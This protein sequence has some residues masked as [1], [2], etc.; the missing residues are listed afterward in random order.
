MNK[1]QDKIDLRKQS[2]RSKVF[3]GVIPW[4]DSPAD[5]RPCVLDDNEERKAEGSAELE[6]YDFCMCNPPFFGSGEERST[7]YSAAAGAI[8]FTEE[9][10]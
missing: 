6:R 3:E 1:L 8:S 10:H 2:N 7:R 4:H 9:S 5:G